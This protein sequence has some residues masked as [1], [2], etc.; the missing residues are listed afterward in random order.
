MNI[1]NRQHEVHEIALQTGTPEEEV[2]QL[3]EEALS[4]LA[5]DAVVKDYLLLLASKHVRQTLKNRH[6]LARV[7]LSWWSSDE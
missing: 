4:Y 6:C 3:Y 1:R 2:S 7:K 5:A